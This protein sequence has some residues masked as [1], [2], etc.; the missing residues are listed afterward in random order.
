MNES[1]NEHRIDI[2]GKIATFPL[3]ESEPLEN[4]ALSHP[5]L[6]NTFKNA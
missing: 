6:R 2:A 3:G 5:Q 1:K 4:H